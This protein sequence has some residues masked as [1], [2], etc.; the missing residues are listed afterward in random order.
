LVN[1]VITAPRNL[2]R[3]RRD[4][5]G[6]LRLLRQVRGYD[7]IIIFH[8]LTTQIGVWKYTLLVFASG[9]KV[10]AGL[11]NGRGWFL[12]HR[13]ADHGFGVKHQADYWL[14]VA[15]LVGAKTGDRHL[16]VGVSAEDRLWAASLLPE[17]RDRYAAIHPGSGGFSV[18]R[19]WEAEKFAALA[20]QFQDKTIVLVGGK[21]DDTEK[22]ISQLDNPSINLAGKTTLNQLAA[23]L[24]RCSKFYGADSGVMHLAAASGASVHA[25]FGPSNHL[26]WH[27]FA[28]QAQVIRSGVRCSP[29]S[30]TGHTL[31]LRQGCAARTCM[32]LVSVE[33]VLNSRLEHYAE[34]ASSSDLADRS[35][36]LRILGIPV[37]ATTFDAMLDQI[38]GWVRAKG[39]AH[40]ICTI[41]PEYVM[42]AQN[43]VLL[44][45]I[46]QRSDLNVPDGVGLLWAARRLGKPLPQRVTG[47][48][49]ISLIAQRA[50]E[51][52]WRLFLL[53]AA[54]G[55]ADRVAQLWRERHPGVQI[56]GAYDGDPSAEAEDEI[57]AMI[58]SSRADILFVAYG[59]GKQDHWI[60]RNL[61]RLG[62][63]VALGVGGAFDFVAGVAVRAPLWMQRAGLEWL[64]RLITQ[65]WRWKRM[66]RL[67]RFVIAVYTRG[68]QP[69]RTFEGGKP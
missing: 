50:T 38:G 62:V 2:L 14:D 35:T 34:P 25:V 19:R 4:F 68:S 64:H 63:K 3:S 55:V 10:R 65:P 40:Q 1:E 44:F 15:A 67:P 66:L 36:A 32:K 24:E 27:P 46:L 45:N 37:H 52:G 61:P 48:D 69:P 31:G 22:V 58:R 43:D 21:D 59:Q 39:G 7:T 5:G 54:A 23:V 47:S 12:T 16:H 18:A 11:D 28:E 57:A 56:A 13:A 6:L 29:C 26:A 30:Y 49:G 33:Q 41:N 51:E 17:G 60:A 20:N 9:A 53:G 8:Q 42:Q